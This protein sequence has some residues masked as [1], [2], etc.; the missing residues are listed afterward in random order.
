MIFLQCYVKF[1]IVKKN[2]YLHLLVKRACANIRACIAQNDKRLTFPE[3]FSPTVPSPSHLFWKHNAVDLNELLTAMDF[4]MAICYADGTKASM[5][6]L[7]CS[8]EHFFNVKLG[9]PR[10]A[11]RSVLKRKLKLTSYLD[12]LRQLLIKNS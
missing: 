10:E 9:D 2:E 8:F 12:R 4:D 5:S 11:K 7:V 3:L 6:D 1:V